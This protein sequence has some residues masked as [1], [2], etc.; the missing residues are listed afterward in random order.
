M[1]LISDSSLCN[2][3][4]FDLDAEFS[5]IRRHAKTEVRELKNQI[6]IALDALSG[7]E[8][9][10]FLTNITNKITDSVNDMM[11]E[12][13]S[14]PFTSAANIILSCIDSNLTLFNFSFT[15]PNWKD[16][17][18]KW[19]LEILDTYLT[20]YEKS[21]WSYLTQLEK[22]FSPYT[23]EK[24]MAFADC[25]A[26]CPGVSGSTTPGPDGWG[27]ITPQGWV[28]TSQTDFTDLVNTIGLGVNAKID[29]SLFG[30]Y[31]STYGSRIRTIQDSKDEAIG[32][33]ASVATGTIASDV[34]SQQLIDDYTI[35]VE[36]VEEAYNYYLGINEDIIEYL[37][38]ANESI[39]EV[40]IYIEIVYKLGKYSYREVADN[41]KIKMLSIYVDIESYNSNAIANNAAALA[42]YNELDLSTLNT[43]NNTNG[44]YKS[45][46]NVDKNRINFVNNIVRDMANALEDKGTIEGAYSNGIKSRG[47]EDIKSATGT[48]SYQ[49]EIDGV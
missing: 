6:Q 41:G 19:L 30:G 21:L 23:F 9:L 14:N 43:L 34:N 22:D 4:G 47:R 10:E 18:D 1:D 13:V 11:G 36:D 29:F 12:I 44:G 26:G 40:D 45:S 35:L 42:A 16:I 25:L 20:S 2:T 3:L 28:Y 37:G 8:P 17:L 48:G 49:E 46:A 39:K 38:L 33:L 24:I 31:G 32:A 7:E 27:V 5:N 15:L